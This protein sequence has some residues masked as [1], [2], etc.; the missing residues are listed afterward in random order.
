[1]NDLWDSYDRAKRTHP[2]PWEII[3]IIAKH[4]GISLD[5]LKRLKEEF[6]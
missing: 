6:A 5:E 4:K 1:M 3:D 2:R